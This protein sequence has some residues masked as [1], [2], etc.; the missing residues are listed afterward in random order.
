MSSEPNTDTTPTAENEGDTTGAETNT[1]A[2]H[3][4][5]AVLQCD[6]LTNMFASNEM[7]L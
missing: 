3:A 7:N 4:V 6:S 5:G 2:Q 1:A